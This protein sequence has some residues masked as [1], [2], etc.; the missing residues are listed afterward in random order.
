MTSK[1][2]DYVILNNFDK[3]FSAIK[4]VKRL[5]NNLDKVQGGNGLKD[6]YIN[7]TGIK[8]KNYF[9]VLTS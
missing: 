5:I 2:L 8:P 7:N 1:L 3:Y 6:I 4:T 9:M